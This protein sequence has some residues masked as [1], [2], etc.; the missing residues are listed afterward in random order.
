MVAR[1]KSV[2]CGGLMLA[3]IWLGITLASSGAEPKREGPPFPRIG[4]CYGA[5][6][7]Y[8]SWDEG[9]E[10]W[11][12]LRLIA[13][14]C[15]DLHYDWDDPKWATAAKRAEANLAELRKVNPH[16]IVLPYVD[17]IEGLDNPK[18]PNDW[19]DLNAE[20]KRWSGW[21]G[22]FRINTKRTEVLQY[23]LD[24]VRDRILNHAA[25]DGV[26]YDCWHVDDW[27]VPRTAALRDGKAV[28]MIN[29][30]NLPRSGF[31]QLNGCLAEDEFNRVMEGQV[32]FDEFLA[33]YLRWTRES[34]K[35]A[36][37]MLV[38]H[39]RG[40]NM[41]PWYWHKLSWKER[42]AERER[43]KDT[44]PQALRFGLCTTL[45]GDGYFGYDTANLG[46]GDWW[47]FPE[48]DVPL[49]YPKGPAQKNSDGVWKRA[50]EGGL[51]V[52]NGTPYDAVLRLDG[53]Y[54]DAS[55]DRIARKF[56]VPMFDGRIF[57]PSKDPPST[58]DDIPPR[59]IRQRP[60]TINAVAVGNDLIVVQTPGG[61]ELRFGSDGAPR[62]I[63]YRGKQLLVGGWPAASTAD[64]RPFATQRSS[65]G[66]VEIA[67]GQARLTFRGT[68][69]ASEQR[70]DYT[71]QCSVGPDDSFKFAFDFTPRTDLNL[72]M[73]RQYFF[74]PVAQ[75]RDATVIGGG[76]NQPLP[77]EVTKEPLVA[78][79][80][81]LTIDDHRKSIVIESPTWLSLIDHR[82]WKTEDYLIA[83]YPVHG[84]VKADDR[85]TY[86][87][88]VSVRGPIER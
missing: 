2:A 68:L 22:Y 7:G 78:K 74:L 81:K 21:P 38:G 26:F 73:W 61:L 20:G 39:P 27:L 80:K 77:A 13:G 3:G 63:L 34:R 56:T 71:L 29:D 4:N 88:R 31:D 84:Q 57:V 48:F 47:W 32:D 28:V 33:R 65:P 42:L 59:I 15:L 12:K 58:D 25:F 24:M 55:G 79:T 6:L 83:A 87:I 40:M 18:L 53:N 30:W 49:G 51:V 67:A 50:F 75:Y 9:R 36:V 72:R 1:F 19:W 35:P 5:R 70:V 10:Y 66:K 37:T 52:V 44:D 85:W 76:R 14:G 62:S 17:V 64:Q 11:S 23:N 82:P 69:A 54:R 41:D 8:A 60:K 45:M 16:V 86:E 43:L 46:R